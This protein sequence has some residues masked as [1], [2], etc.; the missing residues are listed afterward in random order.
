MVTVALA[1]SRV[2]MTMASRAT[3][4]SVPIT[5][6]DPCPGCARALAGI[7]ACRS[8]ASTTAIRYERHVMVI[9]T[10]IVKVTRDASQR[11]LIAIPR[12]QAIQHRQHQQRQRG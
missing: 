3:S 5:T 7:A 1:A 11:R 6:F 9:P 2:S 8:T 10:S 12:E 4:V